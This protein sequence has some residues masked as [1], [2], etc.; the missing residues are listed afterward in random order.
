MRP[1]RIDPG[2]PYAMTRL[3]ARVRRVE[4]LFLGALG[5]TAG[6]LL[7]VGTFAGY[8]R[9]WDDVDDPMFSVAGLG[10]DAASYGGE[11][12]FFAVGFLGLAGLALLTAAEAFRHLSPDVELAPRRH[13]WWGWLLVVGVAIAAVFAALVATQELPDDGRLVGPGLWLLAIGTG[14][15]WVLVLAAERIRSGRPG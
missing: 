8:V 12:W 9:G 10:A 4:D 11:A 1:E 3:L 7:V 13:R 14:A 15:W 2:D 6:T 5:A